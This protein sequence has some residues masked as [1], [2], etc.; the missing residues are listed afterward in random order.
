MRGYK[1]DTLIPDADNQEYREIYVTG[2]RGK[3]INL[4]T[5]RLSIVEYTFS[6]PGED[7]GYTYMGKK[8]S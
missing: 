3:K 6:T 4:N 1:I 5:R 8:G 7:K 2:F